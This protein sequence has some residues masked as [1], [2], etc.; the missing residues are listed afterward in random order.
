MQDSWEWWCLTVIPVTRK[1]EAEGSQI[2]CQPQQLSKA[3]RNLV[4][5]CLK[6][7]DKKGWG[8]GTVVKHLLIPGFNPW[9][10][11]KEE[12]EEEEWKFKAG[13]ST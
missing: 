2:Q 3:L 4:R 8:C 6:I 1:A 11:K 10:K 9:Y 13:L 12:E 5:P 7:K